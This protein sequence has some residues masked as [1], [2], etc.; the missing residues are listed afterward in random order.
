MSAPGVAVLGT[1]SAGMRH[2]Q[3]LRAVGATPVAVPV[4]AERVAALRTAG[5]RTASTLAEA[6]AQGATRAAIA[7]DTGRHAADAREALG[8]GMDVLV[9]KPL[10]TTAA[11][12]R[13]VVD[14]A[15]R[16]G[17]PV[18]VG[19]V[20]RGA[21]SLATFRAWLPDLGSL[22]R[23]EV[24]CGSYLPDWRPGRAVEAS[25]S[26]RAEEGGVL[27]DLIHEIDYAGWLFGWPSSLQAHVR[28]L[29]RLGIASEELAD[30]QWT[31][32]EG[33]LVSISL[34]YLSRPPRR[35][36]RAYGTGGTLAWDGIAGTVQWWPA[37]A[38]APRDVRKA[39]TADELFAAQARAWL[40]PG[41]AP[42]RLAA[43]DDGVLALAVCDAARLASERRAE[44]RVE[45]ACPVPA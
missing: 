39:H 36:M 5:W 1:G 25:Y 19:C 20:L 44:V 32:R 3:A 11:E 41:R 27:R 14:A 40:D 22:H 26:A 37:P 31:T 38:G 29:G 9:E 17:R 4:R 34:D 15:A 18:H 8:L 12:A 2:L 7:T 13:T 6:A 23:V 10:A 16:L 42:D 33:A 45:G 28:N 21:D 30:L 24:T 35:W 43:G